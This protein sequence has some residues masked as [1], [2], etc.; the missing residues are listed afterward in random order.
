[1]S[2]R[3]ARIAGWALVATAV[4]LSIPTIYIAATNGP[5]RIPV[6]SY[7]ETQASFELAGIASIAFA[8]FAVVGAFI[9][10]RRPK[11]GLGWLFAGTGPF[12]MLVVLCFTYGYRAMAADPG[13]LPAGRAGAWIGDILGPALLGSMTVFLFLLFPDGRLRTRA[14]RRTAFAASIGVAL[15]TVGAILEPTL[16][17]YEGKVQTPLELQLSPAISQMLLGLGWTLLLAALI[18]SIVLLIGRLRRA[19]GRERDQLRLFVWA[20]VL[21]AAFFVPSF[22]APPVFEG[23]SSLVFFL[24]AGIAVLLI[25]VSVGVAILRHQLLDIDLVIRR[26]V[27]IAILGAS[28]TAIYIAIVVGVGALVGSTGNAALSAIAAA[29]VAL[30]FQPVRRRAQRVADRLVYGERATPYEV[31]HEFS[32]RVAGSYGTEDVLPRMATILGE[33]TGAERAQ[34]WLRVGPQLRSAAAWPEGVARSGSI[35]LGQD[36]QVVI[37]GVSHAVPV[38]DERELLGALSVTKSPSAPVTPTEERLVSDLAL[39]AGLVL[40][41]AKLLEDL[42]ASRGRL[43]AAQDQERR[44]LERNIHDGAQQ[45]LVALQVKQRLAEQLAGRDAGKTKELLAELQVETGRALEDLRNLARGIYPP[46]LADEGL[47]AALE[48]QSKRFTL[49]VVVRTN[50][51]GRYPPEVEATVYFCVLEALQNAAKYSGASATDISLDASDGELS[52]EVSDDGRG[53]DPMTTPRGSG[54]QN[55]T[56]RLEAIGGSLQIRSSPGEGTRLLGTIPFR[57]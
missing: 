33:G 9:V 6:R 24:V 26:T 25:P 12:G 11:N 17:D 1:M 20:S 54:L 21:A 29:I 44:K 5:P 55:M 30:A 18:A 42:R 53:F 28:I 22:T 8:V 36:E 49:P 57:L 32:E 56:D 7:L 37:E 46:L 40:R 4:L 3:T 35:P 2:P 10:S 48:A 43:V 45:Q 34:V 50:G 52:F 51:T 27:V 31:M 14:E 39:Q 47:G 15:A 38:R 16:F 23:L 13:S 19:V 41:N